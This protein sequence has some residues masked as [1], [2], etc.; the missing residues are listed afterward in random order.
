MAAD[1]L[2]VLKYQ[3]AWLSKCSHIF[4]KILSHYSLNQPPTPLRFMF[5]FIT[6]VRHKRSLMLKPTL[7]QSRSSEWN[8]CSAG[9][10][11]VC[12]Q[13]W[14]NK[15]QCAHTISQKGGYWW[16]SHLFLKDFFFL[17]GEWCSQS[18][19]SEFALLFP[20]QRV[21]L[22]D[23]LT[24]LQTFVLW[25]WSNEFIS[26]APR[27]YQGDRIWDGGRKG[28]RRWVSEGM[29]TKP[30]CSLG[31]PQQFRLCDLATFTVKYNRITRL[32]AV[33]STM[34][35]TSR[36]QLSPLVNCT[37]TNILYAQHQYH[38]PN[39]PSSCTT[40]HTLRV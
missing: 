13:L 12:S 27:T 35:R 32:N 37:I 8:V 36:S 14:W 34:T 20:F 10:M 31:L 30:P 15:N 19:S 28:E 11:S 5:I 24:F 4:K 22:M 21:F 18:V 33:H 2:S 1:S 29:K 6:P 16:L 40:S 7:S 25:D 26:P 3:S 17:P 39:F 23:H 9:V 38:H